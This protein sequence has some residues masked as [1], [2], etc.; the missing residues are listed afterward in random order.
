[1]DLIRWPRRPSARVDVPIL[2]AADRE[3]C[4]APRVTGGHAMVIEG[5]LLEGVRG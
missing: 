1:V 4:H 3:E 2:A 5:L